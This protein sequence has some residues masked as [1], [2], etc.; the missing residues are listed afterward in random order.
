M[1]AKFVISKSKVLEQYQLVDKL[2]S[3][4]SYSSKTNPDITPIL[5]ENTT[6]LF[7]I[8]TVNE[9]KHIKERSRC[10]F[11]AQGWNNRLIEQLLDQNINKF[12]VDNLTDLDFLIKY[13][14]DTNHQVELMLRVKL[15]EHSIRTER[16][17]VFGMDCLTI[18]KKI[19]ELN[20]HPNIT[21]LGIHFHRKTQNIAEWNLVYEIEQM[22]D[23]ETLEIINVMNIGGG[24]PSIYAN[25]NVKVFDS[26]YKK[27][28]DLKKWLAEKDIKLML[29][30]GRFI[31]APAVKLITNII[32]LYENNIIV[33]ASI[34]NSDTDAIIVPV[35][36]LVEG[37]LNKD[38]GDAYVIKGITPCSMDLFRYRVYLKDPQVG[39]KIV[40]LNAGAYNFTTDFCDLEKLETEVIE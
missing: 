33:D 31:S 23:K 25:V 9:L 3:I 8:H 14:E 37:E 22:F 5:E 15:K 28:L 27:I 34:Y 6:C 40:F 19:K 1:K 18:N 35:K 30:P 13:L 17:F 16:Y 12:G 11:L 38:E 4:T 32:S 2:S 26:I 24:L 20:D 10:F 36:L 7:T 39:D 29:E 21:A